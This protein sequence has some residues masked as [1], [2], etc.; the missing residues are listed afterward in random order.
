[1]QCRLVAALRTG[2]EVALGGM[3]GGYAPC[4]KPVLLTRL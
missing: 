4:S 2:E 1:M 3:Q